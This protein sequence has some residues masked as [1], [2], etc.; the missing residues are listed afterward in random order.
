MNTLLLEDDDFTSSS[1]AVIRGKRADHLINTVGVK[2]GSAI[3]CGKVG[4]LLGE[5]LISAQSASSLSIECT[6]TLQPPTPCHVELICALPRPKML[7]RIVRTTAELGVKRLILINSFRVEKSYWQSPVL[8]PQKLREFCIEGL[9]QAGDTVLP[10]IT[11]QKR[12]K[13]FVE[14]Q[15]PAITEGKRLILAHPSAPALQAAETQ[16]ACLLAVGPEGGFIDYEV[17]K[18]QSAGFS[19][20]CFGERVMRCDTAIPFLIA[21]LG[22]I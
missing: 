5:A 19:A 11:L 4:G 2:A 21:T 10:D 3:R 20:H 13:P 17:E 6:F 9:Q 14:D 7:R 22:N 15:L 18:L 12:F 8:T 1:S 16:Q